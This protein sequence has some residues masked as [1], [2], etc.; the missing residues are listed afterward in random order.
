MRSPT[1]SNDNQVVPYELWTGKKPNLKN[2]RVFGCVAYARKNKPQIK[3]KLDAR[4]KKC[5]MLGYCDNGYKLWSVADNKIIVA[6]N[7]V[8]NEKQ[9]RF[10]DFVTVYGGNYNGGA[11]IKIDD[12]SENEGDDV[13]DVEGVDEHP[14]AELPPEQFE[15]EIEEFHE[16]APVGQGLRRGARVRVRPAHFDDYVTLSKVGK[17]VAQ[18]TDENN[19]V[20]LFEFAGMSDLQETDVD[21][22]PENYESIKYRGDKSLWLAAVD[23]ELTALDINKTWEVTSL[24]KGKTPI[25]SKWVF[26][27]KHDGDGSADRYKARLV[28]KGCAQKYGIDYNETYAPVAKLATVR[29]FLCLAN[30]LNLYIQQLDVK[31]A[32]LNGDLKEEIYMWPPEGLSVES[33]K[34]CKLNKTLYGLKQAPMEWNRK[35]DDCVKALGFTQCQADT[36]VYIKRGKAGTVYLLLYV[37]DFLI[38]CDNLSLLNEIKTELMSRFQMRDL[39]DVS[40]FLGIKIRKIKDGM[41]LSQES[42]LKKVLKKF[43]LDSSKPVD[44]P[45]E[46]RPDLEICDQPSVPDSCPYR[47]AIGSLMYSCMSTRPDFCTAVN[48]FSQFQS[49]ATEKHWKGVKRIFR[50]IQGTVNYGIWFRGLS[51]APLVLYADAAFANDPDR[52]SISGFV[53]EM[54]GD[55]I[56]W[57]TRKQT[58]V[59]KSSTEAEYIA[60]AV[61]VSELLWARQLIS[62]LGISICDAIPVYE[63]NQGVIHALKRW[64]VKRLK[65]VDVKYN[66]IKDLYHKNIISVNYIPSSDQKADIMTKGLPF[67][68][69]SRHRENIGMCENLEIAMYIF[70]CK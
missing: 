6:R 40:Y 66:F 67:E 9:N 33:G 1:R 10:D 23:E 12:E 39:G 27:V 64:D 20:D 59:A 2:L 41:F 13:D 54:F 49:Y 50:Y 25:K 56:I 19:C 48:L 28:I 63:D 47:S 57:G 62:E 58:C 55:P 26:T 61:A 17:F 32:F 4:V 60:L 21:N 42:Y 65:H 29:V 37:D 15:P 52:K 22:V 68:S 69:F 14:D 5:I 16:P 45:L 34:V 18:C 7:V 8:F 70:V 43:K 11:M 31:C 44:T 35:F 46:P 30:R 24:P 53:I 36:C 38:A 3:G 51:E